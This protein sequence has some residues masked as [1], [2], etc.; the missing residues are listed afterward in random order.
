[1]MASSQSF[2]MIHLRMLLSPDPR[3]A[4]KE[5][6][7]AEDDRQTGAMLLL[8]R[9]HQL[10][11]VDHVLEKKQ[12][13]IIDARQPGPKPAGMAELFVLSLDFLLLLFP[14]NAKGRVGEEIVKF[15]LRK[16]V[17]CK[18]VSITNIVVSSILVYLLD[19]H[20]GSG[21]GERALVVVLAVY[22]KPRPRVVLAQV[23]LGLG[24]HP[25]RAASR[26]QELPH[27]AR[28]R[29]QVIVV[30]EQDI[31]HQTDDLAGGEMVAGC[32][33]GQFVES[34][35]QIFEDQS[36]LLVWNI[37]RMQ[38]HLTKLGDDKIED[39]RLAHL[40]DLCFELEEVEDG[41]DVGGESFNV[42][43]KV[44]VNVVRVAL[45][46]FKIEWRMIMESLTGSP[47]QHLIERFILVLVFY[48][49]VFTKH[50][51]FRWS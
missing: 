7:P 26:V 21:G 9:Q 2:S 38:I 33:I 34:A 16:L 4:G 23:V 28:C 11:L 41:V 27:G 25:A 48:L 30:D 3:A 29:K 42:A 46:F 45:E 12:R 14:V 15:M 32:L 51:R 24:E 35:N 40:L 36:H 37:V 20:V 22:I 19:Q 43:H 8:G 13:P 50:L 17:I 49:S 31:H 44:L 18:A 1:M 5:R 47:V 6:R 10:K 39:V